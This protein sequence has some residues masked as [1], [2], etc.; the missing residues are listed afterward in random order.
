MK[1][2]GL[3]KKRL[4]FEEVEGRRLLSAVPGLH[5]AAVQAATLA[6]SSNW[7]GYAITTQS[8]YAVTAVSGAWAVPQVTGTGQTAYAAAWVGIDGANSQ[9]VEQT[10]TLS[11]ISPNGTASYYAWY[12][13]YPNNM[14]SITTASTD[15]V[16][17]GDS[18]SASVEY[19]AANTYTLTITD[20]N[21][22]TGWTYTTVQHT[23][24]AMARSSAEWI[25]EAPSSNFGVLPLANF[26]TMGFT[27]AYATVGTA[28]SVDSGSVLPTTPI[29]GFSSAQVS[30]VYQID[31]AGANQDATSALNAAGT[32][33]TVTYDGPTTT[34]PTPTNPT[35]PSR[36]HRGGRYGGSESTAGRAAVLSS[37]VH[38]SS[39]SAAQAARDQF[40]ALLGRPV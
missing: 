7:S 32:G 8:G 27:S 23:S 29:S 40:F 28:S 4:R 2:K 19:T 10:G 15:L 17:P 1:A 25:M 3:M 37:Q 30:D 35:P 9:T 13:M 33:F 26:G 20:A 6:Q 24:S 31:M 18:M 21:P 12:E 5:A 38:G 16:K 11:Q 39:P 22:T 14:V 36:H 34:T